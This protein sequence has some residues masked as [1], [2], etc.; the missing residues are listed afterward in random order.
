MRK[1][2]LIISICFILLSGC[3]NKTPAAADDF[4]T[5]MEERG[6]TVDDISAQYSEE[7]IESC[8]LALS[9]DDNYQIEF[10]I[11]PSDEQTNQAYSN[12][13]SHIESFE[14]SV[15]T[16]KTVSVAN[17]S[18][19]ALTTNGEYHVVSRV[20]RTMVYASVPVDCKSDVEA[21]MAELGYL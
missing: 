4:T 2:I 13:K 3:S 14:D 15:Y 19:Y 10:Y 9:E 17:Y 7:D 12:L 1:N 11:W 6:Y 18:Y 16:S 8:I 20:D 21:A 5:T